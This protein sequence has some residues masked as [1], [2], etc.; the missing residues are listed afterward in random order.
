MPS[1]VPQARPSSVFEEDT[2][3][4]TH[5]EPSVRK[6]R[7]CYGS[8]VWAVLKPIVFIILSLLTTAAFGLAVLFIII[9]IVRE[10]TP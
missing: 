6:S 1:K 2:E 10:P 7:G 3:K 9:V 4:G 5:S 8:C